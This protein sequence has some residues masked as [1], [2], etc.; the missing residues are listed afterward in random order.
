VLVTQGDEVY[1]FS[2]V[3]KS[4]YPVGSAS[5]LRVDAMMLDLVGETS[6]FKMRFT[7]GAAR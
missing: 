4:P 1:T 5:T 2:I 3:T 7:G 6:P